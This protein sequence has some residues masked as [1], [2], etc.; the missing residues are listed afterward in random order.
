[1]RGIL[2]LILVVGVL[3]ACTSES[4][5]AVQVPT[6]AV[7]P[8]ETQ[9][10]TITPTPSHTPLPTNTETPI[11]TATL[12]PIPTSDCAVGIWWAEVEPTVQEFLDTADV[13]AQTSRMSLSGVVLEMRQLQRQFERLDYP[14]CLQE[15]YFELSAGMSSATDGFTSFMGESEIVSSVQLGLATQYFWNASELLRGRAILNEYRIIDASIVWGGD[16]PNAATA[17]RY[18]A[19]NTPTLTP[20][21]TFT[22]SVTPLPTDITFVAPTATEDPSFCSP[23]AQNEGTAWLGAVLEI[24][25][26]LTNSADSSA[27]QTA[28]EEVGQLPYPGCFSTARLEFMTSLQ[29]AISALTVGDMTTA[30]T[31]MQNAT[32]AQSRFTQEVDR[33]LPNR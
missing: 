23:R 8:D 19:S 10:P 14:S 29:W 9:S 26:R 28:Y 31:Y 6:L 11:P 32:E 33:I 25:D 18:A 4:Q 20:T 15:I 22:P 30:E 2:S 27:F 24:M 21:L 16:S 3:A 12:T 13:A 1:M 5:Q 7:L 17:T